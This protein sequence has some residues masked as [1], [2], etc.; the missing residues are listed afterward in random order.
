MDVLNTERNLIQ[1]S[2]DE[3][4]GGTEEWCF[5]KKNK[6]WRKICTLKTNRAGAVWVEGLVEGV[7]YPT[8]KL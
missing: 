6:L 1:I 5:D 2:A 4:R 3:G 8:H 7:L